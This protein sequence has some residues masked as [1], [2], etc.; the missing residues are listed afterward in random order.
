MKWLASRSSRPATAR[1][2]ERFG[3]QPCS[4]GER[5]L[6]E[7]AGIEPASSACKAV[8][9]PFELSSHFQLPAFAKCF[10]AS[11]GS[12]RVSAIG[13]PA[14]AV[15]RRR[16]VPGVGF[17]PT[18]PH[19]QCGAFTRLASQAI[20][21]WLPAFADASAGSLRVLAIACRP[22]PR[23]GEGWCGRRELNPR[24]LSGAQGTLPLSHVRI[25]GA[26]PRIRTSRRPTCR[27]HE[28]PVLQ[29][30]GRR[31]TLSE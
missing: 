25:V 23:S 16:L 13:L 3:G 9:L 6:V 8:A 14:E 5:R 19:F 21:T 20:C 27:F 12:L 22:K 29:T 7:R 26:S 30:G 18:S 17:E 31:G 15:K 1:L 28:T 4:L 11:A 10:T 2:R 24:P